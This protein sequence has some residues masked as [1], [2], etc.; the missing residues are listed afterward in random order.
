MP[1]VGL[2]EMCHD[3]NRVAAFDRRPVE[4][5]AGQCSRRRADFPVTRFVL[6]V[7]DRVEEIVAVPIH[8]GAMWPLPGAYAELG[9]FEY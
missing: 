4:E 8:D 9:R 3:S 6:E 5:F 1:S 7:T 2:L